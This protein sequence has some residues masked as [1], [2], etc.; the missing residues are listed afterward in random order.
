MD[1]CLPLQNMESPNALTSLNHVQYETIRLVCGGIKTPP[2]AACEIDANIRRT[3][4]LIEVTERYERQDDKNSNK[5][6]STHENNV[7]D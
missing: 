5:E 7:E 3:R 2:T 4:A 6:I 1:Y